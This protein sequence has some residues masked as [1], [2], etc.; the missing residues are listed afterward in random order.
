MCRPG[1]CH[2]GKHEYTAGLSMTWELF[3]YAVL[4]TNRQFTAAGGGGGGGP[5]RI[6]LAD[7]LDSLDGPDGSTKLLKPIPQLGSFR[8]VLGLSGSAN[9][10]PALAPTLAPVTQQPITREEHSACTR[11]TATSFTNCTGPSEEFSN[12]AMLITNDSLL[13]DKM[14]TGTPHYLPGTNKSASPSADYLI[15]RR[16][17]L[18]ERL[19]ERYEELLK[20]MNEELQVHILN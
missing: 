17:F 11:P 18:L 5:G 14:T 3:H 8:R 16:F 15:K 13:P 10:E 20:L 2:P 12:Q 7:Y 9:S 4:R 1:H 19:V 6:T